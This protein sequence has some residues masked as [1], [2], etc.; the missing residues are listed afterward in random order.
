MKKEGVQ[1]NNMEID[2]YTWK[3]WPLFLWLLFLTLCH[4]TLTAALAQN[5]S[6]FDSEPLLKRAR[7]I[8]ETYNIR[9][10]ENLLNQYIQEKRQAFPLGYTF[11]FEA[12]K[13]A[14]ENLDTATAI[15]VIGNLKRLYPRDDELMLREGIDAALLNLYTKT[16]HWSEG[17]KLIETIPSNQKTN[18]VI[19]AAVFNFNRTLISIGKTNEAVAVSRGFL[20]DG[21]EMNDHVMP[22]GF[23]MR[24]AAETAFLSY[25]PS[26]ALQILNKIEESSAEYYSSNRI[27]ILM[28]KVTALEQLSKP[29]EIA[30]QLSLA[31]DL[32]QQG[33]PATAAEQ[34]LLQ[35]RLKAYQ[36]AG[37]LDDNNNV[38]AIQ[39]FKPLPGPRPLPA[40]ETSIKPIR[41][42]MLVAFL[43]TPLVI[44]FLAVKKRFYR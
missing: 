9:E 19:N 37:W 6:Q 21:A 43:L 31:Y 33:H 14:S 41:V 39:A 27:G 34:G 18:F 2:F 17:L 24:Q 35:N 25:N 30:K 32:Q 38:N 8:F 4:V 42:V 15:K 12:A 29:S 22:T 16:Q 44:G 26:N 11:G 40:F 28:E 13:V 36:R 3:K 23:W 5:D 1:S 20:R 7:I 10:G